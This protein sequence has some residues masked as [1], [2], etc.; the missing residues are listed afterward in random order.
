MINLNEARK[1]KRAKYFR[2]ALGCHVGAALAF[3]LSQICREK[4]NQNV[5][6]ALGRM[7]GRV[8]CCLL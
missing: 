3:P 4:E 7:V 6:G 5:R 2:V 8:P 1:K